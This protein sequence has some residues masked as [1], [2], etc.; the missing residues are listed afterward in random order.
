MAQAC[1]C[2]A[3]LQNTG[4]DCT[5]VIQTTSQLI[6]VSYYDADGNQTYLDLS[7]TFNTAYFTALINN[8]DPLLRW[9]PLGK[10]KNIEETRAE[11]KTEEF[12][13]G[14]KQFIQQGIRS[15]MG[16]IPKAPQ[17]LLAPIEGMRCAEVGVYLVDNS[18]NLI[19]TIGEQ[20]NCDPAFLYPIRI[21]KESID[22]IFIKQTPDIGQKIS[23]SFNFDITEQDSKLRMVT[24]AELN[25]DLNS[26]RGL[27]DVCSVISG[28]DVTEFTAELRVTGYG[29]P[30]NPVL[31]EGLVI[32]DFSLYNTTDAAAVTISTLT[33]TSPGVYVFT[34]ASQTAGDILE[35]TP[36]KNGYDFAAVVAN[37]IQIPLT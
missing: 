11:S 8:A 21:D 20:D 36:V 5:P 22:A 18:G 7:D 12:T 29:T 27:R 10:F 33:E 30:R 25:A 1:D 26:V 32:T 23:V 37:T 35:L 28:I 31:M 2:N 24:Q 17:Q 34:F 6:F 19:G 14:S 16:V 13:D 3:T 4:T 15:F 9:R